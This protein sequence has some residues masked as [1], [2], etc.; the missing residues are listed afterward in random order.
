MLPWVDQLDYY[1]IF[2]IRSRVFKISLDHSKKVSIIG[3]I[4][5][6][7]VVLQLLYSKCLPSLMYGLEACPLVKLDLSSL[8]FEFNHFFMKLFKTNN[9]DVV[10]VC[11]Q[12]FSFEMLS[13]LWKK[14][15]ALFDDKIFKFR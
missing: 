14:R 13:S 4:A 5:N 6:E 2:I 11:Q 10:R 9:L 7:D 12:Y 3:R 1:G 8:D 15:L